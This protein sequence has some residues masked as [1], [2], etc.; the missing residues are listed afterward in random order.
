[1]IVKHM[2]HHIETLDEEGFL[3]IRQRLISL[4]FIYFKS[5]Y[6]HTHTHTIFHFIHMWTRLLLCGWA[7][8]MW[9]VSWLY[10]FS[11][12]YEKFYV[13]YLFVMWWW[14]LVLYKC[15]VLFSFL[16]K[17]CEG[18]CDLW[19]HQEYTSENISENSNISDEFLCDRK[20][21]RRLHYSSFFLF[22]FN[23]HQIRRVHVT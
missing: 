2:M 23:S 1:M 18:I 21:N 14:W 15:V 10:M 16:V 17:K 8:L 5:T 4:L 12:K 6:A 9:C 20:S 7:L 11:L 19:Y 3:I 22:F 13:Y